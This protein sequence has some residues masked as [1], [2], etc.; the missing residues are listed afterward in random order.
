MYIADNSL[1]MVR[2]Q[3]LVTAIKVSLTLGIAGVDCAK[4][5][6]LMTSSTIVANAYMKREDKIAMFYTYRV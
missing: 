3:D 2:W 5:S 6:F 1:A 4:L